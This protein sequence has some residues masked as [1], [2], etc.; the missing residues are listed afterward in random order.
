M[1]ERAALVGGSLTAAASSGGEFRVVARL[2]YL[3]RVP[4]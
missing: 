3:S 4:A 2:P 1:K